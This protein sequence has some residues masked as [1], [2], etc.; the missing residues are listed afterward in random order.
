MKKSPR[1]TLTVDLRVEVEIIEE[2]GKTMRA[3]ILRRSFEEALTL[4]NIKPGLDVQKVE[5]IQ[6]SNM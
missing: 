5:V 6:Y 1:I 4:R 2:L 3:D